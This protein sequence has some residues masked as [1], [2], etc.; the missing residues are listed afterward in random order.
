MREPAALAGAVERAL[1]GGVTA[2]QLRAKGDEGSRDELAAGLRE[3][4]RS[5]GAAFLV[6][7][8]I[9]LTA[10]CGADG[11]HLGPNDAPALRAR[12]ELGSCALVGV[13]AG[14][15]AGLR[16]MLARGRADYIGCGNL[17]GTTT[18]ADAS[19]PIGLEGLRAVLRATPLPVVGIG[20]VDATNAR[21]VL[22]AG[23]AGVAVASAILDAPD[24][25]RAAR[26]L[27]GAVEAGWADARR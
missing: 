1:S 7:D 17:F 16:G 13:S 18:K 2:V 6:N 20:G 11:V 5:A 19:A 12:R 10:R 15:P 4:C 14:S 22:A 25:G 23:A 21:S 27:R 3:L 24:P 26:E 9:G 8:D